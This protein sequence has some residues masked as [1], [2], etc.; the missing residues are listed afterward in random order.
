MASASAPLYGTGGCASDKENIESHVSHL[1]HLGDFTGAVAALEDA[2]R[3]GGGGDNA[4]LWFMLGCLLSGGGGSSGIS[5]TG[6]D[7][8]PSG[9]LS[10]EADGDKAR[11]AAVAYVGACR[12]GR[13]QGDAATVDVARENLQVLLRRGLGYSPSVLM[14]AL[15]DLARNDFIT[16][17]LR[18]AA[19]SV[20]VATGG[21]ARTVA[22]VV[23][24][25]GWEAAWLSRHAATLSIVA[26]VTIREKG[27]ALAAFEV[28]L[29]DANGGQVCS[30]SWEDLATH[31]EIVRATS[32][33]V[34][35][36]SCL[37][38][39]P[40]SPGFVL[41]SLAR[42]RKALHNPAGGKSGCGDAIK[43]ISFVPAS[44]RWQGGS[45]WS[46]T[47]QD[48]GVLNAERLGAATDGLDY[49]IAKQEMRPQHHWVELGEF[50]DGC[51]WN[52]SELAS[53]DLSQA[54]CLGEQAAEGLIYC[55]GGS[56]SSC[57]TADAFVWWI[58]VAGIKREIAEVEHVSFCAP[59][60][61]KPRTWQAA[62]FGE[63]ARSATATIESLSTALAAASS[64]QR[65]RAYHVGMLNDEERTVFYNA[66]LQTAI[67]SMPT[68]EPI[69]ALDLG[70]GTGLL[71]M[72]LARKA[73]KVGV[74]PSSQVRVVAV[75][76]EKE[77]ACIAQ[78][79]VEDNRLADSIEVVNS[80]S[81]RLDFFPS[82]EVPQA[83]AN[84]CVHEIFGSDPLSECVLPAL[85]H[86][87][88]CLLSPGAI[89]VP[90]RCELLCALCR[91][92]GLASLFQVPM[93]VQG[94][95][96][97]SELFRDVSPIFEAMSVPAGTDRDRHGS[98]EAAGPT[99]DL[100]WLTS[101]TVASYLDLAELADREACRSG[102]E[103]PVRLEGS[104]E[105]A[106]GGTA[107]G[108]AG[109]IAVAF[110]FRLDGCQGG[111]TLETGP[112]SGAARPWAPVFQPLV[113]AKASDFESP[114]IAELS[115]RLYDDRIRFR[116]VRVVH[117]DEVEED[118]GCV[119]ALFD[120]LSGSDKDSDAG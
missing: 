78:R 81:T 7:Q 17:E 76:A 15:N 39:H 62:V 93:S 42:L 36:A 46:P 102:D 79:V 101:P 94:V 31:V 117:Q 2:V 68:D 114:F 119:G 73:L 48:L 8:N 90:S 95:R 92:R 6:G 35:W 64:S 29:A 110:W 5:Q 108:S 72:M 50:N 38:A 49:T 1:L 88:R 43:Q 118:A 111:P 9:M 106:C 99:G 23:D 83:R 59:L 30:S 67:T 113:G 52:E 37:S 75:E 100:V 84:L 71:S 57:D 66:A 70:A 26:V 69:V 120:D 21:G 40:V 13:A 25:A 89:L 53:L 103:R 54:W 58:S 96:G 32:A 22:I 47:L 86:A 77:L 82:G 55:S 65:F 18:C 80:L 14:E 56:G 98:T 44:V 4:R 109:C 20:D 97:V 11:R 51:Q 33:V 16:K 60:R 105:F 112:G 61:R 10:S 74:R 41:G 104:G 12:V 34:L 28:A 87:R 27:H 24:G 107:N 45:A 19:A 63:V 116:Y 3:G 115:T 85:R 91:G